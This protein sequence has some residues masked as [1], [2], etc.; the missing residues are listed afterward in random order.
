MDGRSE[1][2]HHPDAARP[3]D[4]RGGRS[5]R[6]SDADR[7]AAVRRLTGHQAAGRLTAEEVR[8]RST[9]VDA[10]RTRAD[11]AQVF[12]DLPDDHPVRTAWHDRHWRTHAVLFAVVTTA[13]LV[14][15]AVVRDPDPLPRDYGMD[16]WWPV[17]LA[18]LWA[19]VV[20][21]HLLRTA[22]LLRG[23]TRPRPPAPGPP[24]HRETAPEPPEGPSSGSPPEPASESPAG[25]PADAP[26]PDALAVLTPREIEVLALVGQ[27]HANKDIAAALFIS[28]R[29]ARTHVSNILQKLE[30]TS[31][32]QAAILAVQ[33]GLR[34]QV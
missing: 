10:A 7:A 20:L 31:R 26:L 30:L 9:W 33:A 24:P 11:L 22:G 32:T 28:E 4:G 15:W 5:P 14:V 8:D 25:P 27:G 2:S 6:L 29:T 23:P 1:R 12:A 16:Y 21:L 34:P 3:A 13:L 17:W 18:L 19:T